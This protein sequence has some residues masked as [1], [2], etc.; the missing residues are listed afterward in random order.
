MLLSLSLINSPVAIQELLQND[1]S[2]QKTNSN[3][4]DHQH[5]HDYHCHPKLLSIHKN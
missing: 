1:T 5:Y 4:A 3:Y 2:L